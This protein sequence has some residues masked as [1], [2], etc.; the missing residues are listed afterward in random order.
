MQVY[1]IC[2]IALNKLKKVFASFCREKKLK[3]YPI[4]K[5]KL[6][7]GNSSSN[8]NNSG[9]SISKICMRTNNSYNSG[10]NSTRL[11]FDIKSIL[12]SRVVKTF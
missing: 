2:G 12:K 1:K 10:N 3:S 6:H 8:S 9:R 4:Y 7:S 5:L 11:V